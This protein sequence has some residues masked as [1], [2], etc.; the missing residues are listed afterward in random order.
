MMVNDR[1]PL[2]P[3]NHIVSKLVF[4]KICSKRNGQ[5]DTSLLVN[6]VKRIGLK[7]VLD[8]EIDSDC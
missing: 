6:Y 5:L 8:Y 3:A 2:I 4:K 7:D 1:M